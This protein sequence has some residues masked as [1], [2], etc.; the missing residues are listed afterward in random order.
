M[1]LT[2][3]HFIAVAEI[4]KES[5]ADDQLIQKFVDYFRTENPLFD[6]SR[7]ITASK[8]DVSGMA[9]NSPVA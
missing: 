6:V 1:T 4:L 7:F 5:N 9:E 2:K 8:Q 3:K